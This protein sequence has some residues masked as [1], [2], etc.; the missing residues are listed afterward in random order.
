M[1]GG[2]G[3]DYGAMCNVKAIRKSDQAASRL[4]GLGGDGFLDLC[5]VMNRS[6]RCRY[7]ERRGGSLNRA[8]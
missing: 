3:A 6:K 8:I 2:R 1:A 5:V 7:P 4:A